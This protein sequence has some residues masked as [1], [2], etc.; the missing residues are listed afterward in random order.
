MILTL[1]QLMVMKPTGCTTAYRF[2]RLLFIMLDMQSHAL[3][4]L[5]HPLHRTVIALQALPLVW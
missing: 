1:T 3:R 4:F 2:I 5:P